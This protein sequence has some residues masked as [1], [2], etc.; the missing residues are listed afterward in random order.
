MRLRALMMGMLLGACMPSQV[1]AREVSEV[2]RDLNLAARFGRMDLAAEHTSEAHRKRFLESRAEWGTDVRVVDV[3][4]AQL[5]VPDSEKAEVIVDVS[6]V[7]ID[8]GLLRSTRIKQNWQNP[9]G[10]WQLDG[11]ERI[12]GDFGLLGENVMILRPEMRDTHFPTKTI[13]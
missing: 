7:R 10:G 13:R 9:G 5:N 1:P 6:W 3:E 8:E 11:E 4:L 12:A 2:A